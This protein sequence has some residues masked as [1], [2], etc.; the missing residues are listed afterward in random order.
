[1]VC[2]TSLEDLL[3]EDPSAAI[4][5]QQSK[6]DQFA[7]SRAESIVLFG[8]GNF[9]KRMLGTLRSAGIEPLAFADNN[10]AIWGRSVGGIKVFPPVEAAGQFGKS[11]VFVVS[12]WSPSQH[13]GVDSIVT[14]L[15]L[16]GCDRVAP[17]PWLMW[18]YS[19]SLPY[20]LWDLPS[21]L[22]P[23]REEIMRAYS[24]LSDERSRIEFEAQIRFRLTG[25]FSCLPPPA[26]EEQYFSDLYTSKPDECFVDCGAFDGDTVKA[27][28]EH[29][30]GSFKKIIAFEADPAN[31]GVLGTYVLSDRSLVGR[32][33]CNSSALGKSI[34][35]IRFAGTG[36]ASAAMAQDGSVE[37]DCTT[38]DQALSDESPT[39]IKMD[40]EGA[41]L[42][43]L[44][45]GTNVILKHDPL[46]AVC[47]YHEQNHL[48]QVPLAIHALR[49]ESKLYLRSYRYDGFDLVCYGVPVHRSRLS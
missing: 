7:G 41:E 24:A 42:D 27:F 43:T 48:W 1:M 21:K 35:R 12:V 47:A 20:Y 37:V 19:N 32:A 22:L 40:I 16:L 2:A 31:F 9:G 45:G 29:T 23:Q 17:F 46:L 15:R 25:E 5:R 28:Q 26:T 13:S 8:A 49:P 11:A 34:G 38:L 3:T 39:F 6:F 36:L 33:V 10:Q 18:K 4:S 30:A 44:A 14:Q